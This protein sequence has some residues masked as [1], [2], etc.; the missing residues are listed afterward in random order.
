M[1]NILLEAYIAESKNEKISGI[2]KVDNCN[3][4]NSIG[5]WMDP[6]FLFSSLPRSL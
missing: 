4:N 1:I 5:I 2:Y 3:N 6:S